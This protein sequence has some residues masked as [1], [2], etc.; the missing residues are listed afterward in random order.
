MTRGLRSLLIAAALAGASFGGTAQDRMP[1]LP[2]G[3][4]TEEQAKALADFTAARGQP[5]RNIM[6]L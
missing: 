2:S 4:L 6:R 1:P 5:S 3:K